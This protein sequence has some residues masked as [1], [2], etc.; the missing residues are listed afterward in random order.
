MSW[1]TLIGKTSKKPALVISVP[2]KDGEKLVGVLASAMTIDDLSKL[3]AR[4]RKGTTGFAFL[5]D[6]KGKVVSHQRQEFILKQ[7]NLRKHPLIA[8]YFKTRKAATLEFTEDN[9]QATI[10]HVRGVKIGWVLAIQ[11]SSSEVFAALKRVQLFAAI[12]FGVT[13]VIVTIIAWLA[14]RA[15]VNPIMELT[16]VAE[17]MSLGEL[18]AK[19]TVASRDEV[20]LLAQAIGRMQ[21]SLRLAMKRLRRTRRV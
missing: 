14:A 7:Q 21:T 5:V 15:V 8:Q 2:I 9:K 4:W 20:G 12:L 16:D 19:I 18:D 3:V 1:Q 11:Q 10:G 17:R 13:V 6:E